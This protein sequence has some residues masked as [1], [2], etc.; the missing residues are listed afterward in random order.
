VKSLFQLSPSGVPKSRPPN[1]IVIPRW[2]A[3]LLALFVCLIVIPLAHGA[4]PW[5][6]SKLTH[7]YGWVHGSP[8]F[9]NLPGLIPVGVATALLIWTLIT[10][11]AHAPNAVRLGLVPS[12]LVTDGPYRFTRNPMYVAKISIMAGV[13]AVLW[14]PG[15]FSGKYGTASNCEPRTCA[16]GRTDF[17]SS[18]RSGLS[19]A[20]EAGAPLVGTS[21]QPEIG[22]VMAR[23]IGCV[24]KGSLWAPG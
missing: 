22:A 5:A 15:R 21:Q 3:I 12:V 16:S 17:G 18:I 14:K 8:G 10:G 9:W 11:I 6:I 2:M 24:Q 13:D 1:R 7:R 4:V 23:S 20:Q 19:Y